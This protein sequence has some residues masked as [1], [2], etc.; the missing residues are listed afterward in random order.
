MGG[1][2]FS[3]SSAAV[4]R[5]ATAFGVL[6]VAMTSSVGWAEHIDEPLSAAECLTH[7]ALWLGMDGDE[8]DRRLALQYALHVDPDCALARWQSGQ[9]R[10]GQQWFSVEQAEHLAADDQLRQQYRLLRD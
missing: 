3:K 8:Q 7:T 2:M 6:A 4:R 9:L 1:T 10:V 5:A